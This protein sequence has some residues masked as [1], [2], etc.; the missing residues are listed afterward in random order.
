MTLETY[1]IIDDT[2]TV[3]SSFT[4]ERYLHTCAYSSVNNVIYTFGG[5]TRNGG[6]VI[7]SI[8]KYLLIVIVG[9]HHMMLH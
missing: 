1:R 5:A 9:L 4:N 6:N 2:R 3:G 7:N 8:E